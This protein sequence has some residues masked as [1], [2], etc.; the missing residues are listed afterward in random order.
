MVEAVIAAAHLAAVA[1]IVGEAVVVVVTAVEAAAGIVEEA[2]AAVVVIAG[3]HPAVAVEG[4]GV[5][6]FY[7][8]QLK[9]REVV[10]LKSYFT[11]FCFVHL[12]LR[13]KIRLLHIPY[14]QSF[15]CGFSKMR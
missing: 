10:E 2:V 15:S 6:N 5:S 11:D 3:V 12:M 13:T 1:D 8:Y 9:I 7:I 4:T 14:L